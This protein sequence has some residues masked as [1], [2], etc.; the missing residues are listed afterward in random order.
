MQSRAAQA[1]LSRPSRQDDFAPTLPSLTAGLEARM[2][3][4]ALAKQ[5][6]RTREVVEKSLSEFSDNFSTAQRKYARDVEGQ[7]LAEDLQRLQIKTKAHER[8]IRAARNDSHPGFHESQSRQVGD[9]TGRLLGLRMA[10]DIGDESIASR[11]NTIRYGEFSPAF[12]PDNQYDQTEFRKVYTVGAPV[13]GEQASSAPRYSQATE[14]APDY[15]Y[16]QAPTA[17]SA[18]A[19]E[20]QVEEEAPSPPSPPQLTR[21]AYNPNTYFGYQEPTPKTGEGMPRSVFTAESRRMMRLEKAKR[22]LRLHKYSPLL[23]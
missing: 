3:A 4:D 1:Y 8:A 20:E 16:D 14:S 12:T 7:I 15:E 13:E 17:S 11:G 19:E 18:T 2:R 22:G 23:K 6:D 10:Q 21:K 5:P 9:L